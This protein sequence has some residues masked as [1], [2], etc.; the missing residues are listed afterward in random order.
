[1]KV[2]SRKATLLN[3]H[4]HPTC[5]TCFDLNPTA[6]APVN[7][8]NGLKHS[9]SSNLGGF[10]LP[11]STSK[12]A[13]HFLPSSPASTSSRTAGPSVE[14]LK[15]RFSYTP[16]EQR[17]IYQAPPRTN[18]GRSRSMVPLPPSGFPKPLVEPRSN[19]YRS[20]ASRP[21]G[22]GERGTRPEAEETYLIKT[23]GYLVNDRRGEGRQEVSV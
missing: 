11:H 16:A 22:A 19:G 10:A 6:L 2:C 5:G 21:D 14:D 12:P 4:H 3:I 20:E 7:P 15:N 8:P 17:P 18:H 13:L 9:A 1:M 23:P